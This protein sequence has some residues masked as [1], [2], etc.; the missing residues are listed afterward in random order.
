MVAAITAPLGPTISCMF[1][2]ATFGAV[3]G[4]FEGGWKGAAIG[5][6]IGAFMGANIGM[7]V[8]AFGAGFALAAL[9]ASAIYTGA[10]QGLDG[11]AYMAGGMVGGMIGY[12]GASAV[13]NSQSTPSQSNYESPFADTESAQNQRIEN[14]KSMVGEAS[15]RGDLQG[16]ADASTSSEY[17][18]IISKTQAI[19]STQP[20]R[21][22][23]NESSPGRLGLFEEFVHHNIRY[24][25]MARDLQIDNYLTMVIDKFLFRGVPLSQTAA[26]ANKAAVDG[27]GKNL[28][29]HTVDYFRD[30]KPPR[31]RSKGRFPPW[32]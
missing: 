20:I 29:G 7:G 15:A 4:G 27:T 30:L 3:M 12:Q 9:G 22:V 5:A 17:K 11:L 23:S 14:L 2:G 6:G 10:T 24:G 8:N 32:I 31:G 21:P 18:I 13:I 1:A 25:K 26:A 28:F 16:A 19:Q